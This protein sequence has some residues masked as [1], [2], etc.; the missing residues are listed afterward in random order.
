VVGFH[1]LQ[2]GCPSGAESELLN[3]F[4]N[5]LPLPRRFIEIQ[6]ESGL[7]KNQQIKDSIN[8]LL[9]QKSGFLR[10]FSTSST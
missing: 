9:K 4:Y 6:A 3:N 2:T 1:L 7:V 10:S 8:A 5:K